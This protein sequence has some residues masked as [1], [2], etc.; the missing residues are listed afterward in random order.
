MAFLLAASLMFGPTT[1]TDEIPA[2]P[3]AVGLLLLLIVAVPALAVLASVGAWRNN[4]RLQWGATGALLVFGAV[5]FGL[6][7][8]VLLVGILALLGLF[9]TVADRRWYDV[10]LAIALL[11]PLW[12]VGSLVV[13]YVPGHGGVMI[14]VGGALIFGATISV[15]AASTGTDGTTPDT[16]PA[17]EAPDESSLH[18]EIVSGIAHGPE[19]RPT[20]AAIALLSITVT[21]FHF[22]G[23]AWGIYGRYWF[24]D[25]LTHTLSGFGVA[26]ILYLL[27]PAAFGNT[28]RLFVFLPALVLTIGAVFEVYEYLFREFYYRWSFERYLRDTL[29]DLA[30]DTLGAVLFAL[31]P[32]TRIIGRRER[33]SGDS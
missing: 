19:W 14:A 33:N 3:I 29:E 4:R 15:V 22:L 28:R 24:W 26:G 30:Y 18:A 12:G 32:Y 8:E 31:F 2:N 9:N 16:V 17:R 20:W 1:V 21:V 11:V 23:L 27:R 25:V 6:A 13:V 7:L 5:P 10:W